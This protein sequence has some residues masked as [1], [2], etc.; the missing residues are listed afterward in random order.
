M[1]KKKTIM[2]IITEI[3]SETNR[4]QG[5]RRVEE[6]KNYVLEKF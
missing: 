6:T 2:L 5:L 1:K 4:K 3:I